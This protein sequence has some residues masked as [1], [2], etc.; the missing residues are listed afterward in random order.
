MFYVK[1]N[2]EGQ[3]VR[4]EDTPFAGMDEALEVAAPEIVAWR[5]NHQAIQ[6]SLQQLR[7]SDLD[8]VRVLEDLIQVLIQKGLI[9]ITDLPT[10]AQNKLMSRAEARQALGG[11]ER[12]IGDDND[13]IL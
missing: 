13:G 1:R 4:V 3:L 10:Q 8:M 11:L 12:L 2:S 7:Q 9:S 5:E 6:F